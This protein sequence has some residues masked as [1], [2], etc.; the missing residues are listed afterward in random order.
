M[1]GFGRMAVLLSC[2]LLATNAVLAADVQPAKVDRMTDALVELMPM[3]KIFDLAAAD[4]PTWPMLEKAE[5]FS[6]DEITCV[7]RELSSAGYRRQKRLEAEVYVMANAS[8][9]DEDLRLLEEGA[10]TLMGRLVMGGANAARAGVAF[11]ETEVLKTATNQQALAFMKFM[12]DPGYT[13]L[14]SVSG[15]GDAMNAENSKSEN[16]KAGEELG[17][18]LGAQ[19]VIKSMETCKIPPAKYL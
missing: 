6:G 13:D 1:L 15:I 17:Y 10:A 18:S 19:A 12:T 3:G 7:R 9:I 16:E 5:A 4:D 14:R 2:G 11:D 8:R